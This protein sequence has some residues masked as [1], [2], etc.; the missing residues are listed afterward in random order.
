MRS[1]SSDKNGPSANAIN[2]QRRTMVYSALK[3]RPRSSSSTFSCNNVKPTT[4]KDPAHTTRTN[5]GTTARASV[6]IDAAKNNEPAAT[7]IDNSKTRVLGRRRCVTESSSTPPAT[8]KP[9]AVMNTPYPAAPA[10]STS[11][12]KI[13]P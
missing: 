5:T 12:E 9:S 11:V 1:S 13:E 8:P 10:P 7:K 2:R 3:M 6:D 4:E